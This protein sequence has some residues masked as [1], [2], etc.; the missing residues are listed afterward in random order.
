MEIAAAPLGA[1]VVTAERRSCRARFVH[2]G[3]VTLQIDWVV[4]G[5]RRKSRA[6]TVPEVDVVGRRPG[7]VEPAAGIAAPRFGCRVREVDRAR[8]FPG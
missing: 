1:R 8:L 5:S 3:P 7:R 4:P 2:A 6:R